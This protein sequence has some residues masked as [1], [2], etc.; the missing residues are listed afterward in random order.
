MALAGPL[1]KVVIING[2]I[3]MKDQY[4]VYGRINKRGKAYY[5]VFDN[6][7]QRGVMGKG[8]YSSE[9][10]A[11]AEAERLN[12]IARARVPAPLERGEH[13]NKV[14]LF[15]SEFSRMRATIDQLQEKAD[16]LQLEDE[17]KA[18][19]LAAKDRYIHELEQII[20]KL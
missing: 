13:G 3:I 9:I 6:I 1:I 19:A 10:A 5:I 7:A 14:V 18:L 17:R 16:R 11:R 4:V 12:A 2:V 20:D 8:N 15:K